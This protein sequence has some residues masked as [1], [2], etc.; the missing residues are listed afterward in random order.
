MSEQ[1]YACTVN[2]F[3]ILYDASPAAPFWTSFDNIITKMQEF[4]P[5]FNTKPSL[6]TQSALGLWFHS[7]ICI[8][9]SKLELR[10]M[11]TAAIAKYVEALNMLT[12]IDADSAASV[13]ENLQKCI[14]VERD[15]DELL[16]LPSDDDILGPKD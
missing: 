10:P 15:L 13:M 16:M 11:S 1:F 7:I 8:F 12:G 6:C 9:E 2:K 3:A 14:L 4:N 5:L